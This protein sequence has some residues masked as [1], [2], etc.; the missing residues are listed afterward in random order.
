MQAK[1]QTKLSPIER[2]VRNKVVKGLSKA[3]FTVSSIANVMNMHQ[4]TVSRT[5]ESADDFDDVLKAVLFG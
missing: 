2:A 5:I 1:V 4:S 3:G